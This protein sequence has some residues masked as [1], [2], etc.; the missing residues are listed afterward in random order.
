MIQDK[1]Q[2]CRNRVVIAEKLDATWNWQAFFDPMGL[3]ITGIAAT[4]SAPH[5]CNSKR[6]VARQNLPTMHLPGWNIEVPCAD[7]V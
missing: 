6:F 3:Q 1:V 2:P 4:P 7:Q 5:V